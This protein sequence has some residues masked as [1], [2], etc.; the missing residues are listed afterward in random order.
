[1]CL[2]YLR[3]RGFGVKDGEWRLVNVALDGQP[4]SFSIHESDWRRLEGT[5]QF[6]RFLTNQAASCLEFEA[7]CSQA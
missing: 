5:D 2:E 1:M 6:D 3:D 4:V 7:Q